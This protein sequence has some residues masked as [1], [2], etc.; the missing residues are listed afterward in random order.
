MVCGATVV[1]GNGAVV[2][3]AADVVDGAVVAGAVVAGVVV[4]ATVVAGTVDAGRDVVCDAAFSDVS[5]PP[6]VVVGATVEVTAVVAGSGAVVV[7][8]RAVVVG[9][10]VVGGAS[11]DSLED[12]VVEERVVED[13]VVEDPVVEERD[14]V[15]E[16]FADAEVVDVASVAAEVGDSATVVVVA[17]VVSV[18]PGSADDPH[19]AASTATIS[20]ELTT[21]RFFTCAPIDKSSSYV[22]TAAAGSR[23]P[24]V[25]S[26]QGALGVQRRYASA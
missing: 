25:I 2:V 21:Y 10:P 22:P 14:V 5:V 7:P 3:V 26:A 15:V 4:A 9:R 12:D 6:T 13:P 11:V 18:S 20:T 16:A 24:M 17:S 19:A 23:E 1:D 8:E